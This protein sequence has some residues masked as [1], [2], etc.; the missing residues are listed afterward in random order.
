[1]DIVRAI[2]IL[3]LVM[4]NSFTPTSVFAQS[5]GQ[6]TQYQFQ[7]GGSFPWRDLPQFACTDA[8]NFYQQYSPGQSVGKDTPDMG[9]STGVITNCYL[10][11]TDQNGTPSKITTSIGNRVACSEGAALRPDGTCPP[12]DASVQNQKCSDNSVLANST[13]GAYERVYLT[14]EHPSMVINGGAP[15][16]MCKVLPQ[17]QDKPGVTRGCKA[18]YEAQE[19]LYGPG[20]SPG[21]GINATTEAIIKWDSGASL[22]CTLPLPKPA[23]A[24]PANPSESKCSGAVGQVN[25]VD[26]CIAKDKASLVQSADKKVTQ[27]NTPEGL[28]TETVT[29]NTVCT[30]AGSCTTTTTTT[31]SV[32]TGPATSTSTEKTESKGSFCA[33]TPA[34]AQCKGSG[35]GS[36]SGGSFGGTCGTVPACT[37]DVIQCAVAKSTFETKC[38]LEPLATDKDNNTV[39]AGY[40][41]MTG[42]VADA[43]NPKKQ[44]VE[45]NV[46]QLDRSNPFSSGVSDQTINLGGR[47]GTIVIP[48]AA[49]NPLFLMMGNILVGLT[50]LTSAF[51]VARGVS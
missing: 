51:Y 19:I 21:N 6:I 3:F 18:T 28:K 34:S 13:F 39:K 4:L 20:G 30:G 42:V 50:L 26:V 31:T 47:L 25:G 43:D 23:A 37:G 36:E 9:P 22:G 33:A 44:T 35:T 2:T 5:N 1:M 10:V 32:G 40:A 41:A 48:L 27:T 38:A 29:Q 49:A 24:D 7:L 11:R 16:T 8:V 12:N 17:D 46:G 14:G 15:N 45:K